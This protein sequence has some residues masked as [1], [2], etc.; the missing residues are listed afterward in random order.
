MGIKVFRVAG[1]SVLSTKLRELAGPVGQ[2]QGSALVPQERI[3]GAAGVIEAS[4]KKPAPR[5]LV[6]CRSIKT[7]GALKTKSRIGWTGN[8]LA[9]Q[10]R[11][12]VLQPPDELAA[13]HKGTINGALQRLPAVGCVY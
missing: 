4:V 6:I 5:E 8:E 2:H 12:L 10:Q 13:R 3:G 9:S 7:K 11:R 1:D